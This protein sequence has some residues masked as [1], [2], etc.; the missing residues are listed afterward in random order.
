[1][2]I[3]LGHWWIILILLI[4]LI[5]FGPRRLPELGSA[6]GRAIKEFR[7]ATEEL[8]DEVSK[9]TDHP[10]GGETPPAETKPTAEPPKA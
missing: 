4:V 9:V 7:K 2:P 8:K 6:F 10:S 3:N 5:A 1:M